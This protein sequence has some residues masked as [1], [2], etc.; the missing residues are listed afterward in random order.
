MIR[1]L[2]LDSLLSRGGCLLLAADCRG[3]HFVIRISHPI[4]SSPYSCINAS[5]SQSRVPRCHLVANLQVFKT[6]MTAL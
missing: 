1:Q 3:I 2:P 6:H 4:H 5:I